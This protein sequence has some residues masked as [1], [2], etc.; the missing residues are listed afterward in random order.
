MR[1]DIPQEPLYKNI[2]RKNATDQ[3]R[4]PHFVR[5]CA[6]EMHLDMSTEP[7]YIL[8]TRAR[9]QPKRTQTRHFIGATSCG[10]LQIKWR[11]P[12][13]NPDFVRACASETHRDISQEATYAEIY[14]QNAADQ[15][16]DP[17]F[18]RACAVEMHVDSSQKPLDA[19]I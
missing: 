5:A 19:E 17:H 11:G 10:N 13:P 3:N 12:E 9:P 1:L 4:E 16:G 15:N 2:C 18:V 6:V 14:G 8:R 7:L